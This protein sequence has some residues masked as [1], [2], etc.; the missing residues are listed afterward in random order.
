MAKII[1]LGPNG[2]IIE[3][4][5]PDQN[6]D[7]A[8]HPDK[9]PENTK[10]QVES[11]EEIQA[12]NEILTGKVRSTPERRE[13]QQ[14]LE[15]LL[16]DL[17]PAWKE[18]EDFRQR[19]TQ[20]LALISVSGIAVETLGSASLFYTG[21]KENG[22]SDPVFLWGSILTGLVCY[23]AYDISKRGHQKLAGALLTATFAIGGTSVFA[24]S[25]SYESLV[26]VTSFTASAAEVMLG[27]KYA[28][29]VLLL[30]MAV[31]A[32]FLPIEGAEKTS[33][34]LKELIFGGGTVMFFKGVELALE[35]RS[36]DLEAA[37]AEEV[38]LREQALAASKAK[39]TFLSTMTHELR[40]PL[41]A[42]I[43]YTDILM[44]M[45]GDNLTEP[46]KKYLNFTRVNAQHLMEIIN[47]IL[48]VARLE[49][50]GITVSK[51]Q[52]L[53]TKLI[54]QVRQTMD[55]LAQQKNITFTTQPEDV[56]PNVLF[57]DS[58]ML[59]QIIINLVNNAIKFTDRGGSVSL[60]I[61]DVID[62]K[63]HQRRWQ[64]IVSDTG[65]GMTKKDMEIIFEQFRQVQEGGDREK[66][67]TGLGL[68]V[69]KGFTELLEGEIEVKSEPGKGSQF[70]LTFPYGSEITP[71]SET[72]DALEK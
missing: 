49:G 65:R 10:D 53:T 52:V 24:L 57:T 27:N 56:G 28:W 16:T 13:R 26:S 41:N 44:Q 51:A 40:T 66:G 12:V 30:M 48:D 47:S 35:K 2:E 64:V 14:Q 46:Q 31:Q 19:A 36:Q 22:Q 63:T 9:A 61:N 33:L 8:S 60:E 50:G 37:R 20:I 6:S 7:P 21:M 29:A 3:P 18:K 11:P 71:K 72:G 5:K 15:G 1:E 59:K 68:A 69:V 25:H 39:S 32:A 55:V 42:I 38:V 67:G 43:G 54:G 70:I 58:Q 4:P 34:L 23:T 45:D 62:E 17:I